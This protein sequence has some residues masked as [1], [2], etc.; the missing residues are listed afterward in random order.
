MVQQ[1]VGQ[2]CEG[3]SMKWGRNVTRSAGSGKCVR[4]VKGKVGQDCGRSARSEAGL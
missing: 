3:V 4:R 2:K 1:Q